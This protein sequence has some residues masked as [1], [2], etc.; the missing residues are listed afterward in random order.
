MDNLTVFHHRGSTELIYSSDF[1]SLD[2]PFINA[3]DIAIVDEKIIPLYPDFLENLLVKSLIPID[4]GENTKTLNGVVKL[5]NEIE[6][7]DLFPIN[8]C[9]VVGGG[10]VQDTA[11]TA[12]SLLKRGVPW[13]F[14]PTTLLSQADS[15]IGS[16]TSINSTNSKNQYG[17]FYAPDR[18]YVFDSFLKSL[19]IIDLVSGV[20]DALHYLCLDIISNHAFV[21]DL[22]LILTQKSIY[23]SLVMDKLIVM[24]SRC[25]SIK[26]TYIESDE[27]DKSIRKHLNLG[28]S[29]AHAIESTFQYKIPHGIAVIYGI[30]LAYKLSSCMYELSSSFCLSFQSILPLLYALC[31]NCGFN[32]HDFLAKL[33]SNVDT[34][35]DQLRKDKKNVSDNAR[36]ILFDRDSVIVDDIDFVTLKHFISTLSL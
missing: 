5:L 27:F 11:A 36:L 17:V 33:Q 35:L 24:S 31:A 14:V 13:T 10:T 15:C 4:A 6:S 8:S 34:F 2:P 32:S 21:E 1:S 26:K 28:H 12:L 23:D 22:L 18:V 3:Y 16:K 19:P 29:F 30:I 9:I 25:H 7:L 20:G